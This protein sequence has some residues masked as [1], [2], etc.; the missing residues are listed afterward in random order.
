MLNSDT[1]VTKNWLDKIHACAYSNDKIATVSPLSN[2]ATICSIPEFCKPNNIPEGF[3]IDTF[4]SLVEK[5]SNRQYL[6]S[7]TCPGFCIFIKRKVIEEVGYFDELFS[8]AYGEED[9]FC[10]KCGRPLKDKLCTLLDT[11][12]YVCADDSENC[13]KFQKLKKS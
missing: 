3:S 13:I 2:N 8:P 10:V 9:D 7:P 12:R 1:I 6:P 5:N 4:S 11:I